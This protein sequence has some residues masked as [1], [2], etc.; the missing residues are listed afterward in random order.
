[1]ILRG[2][3]FGFT[4][5]EIAEMIGMEEMNMDEIEQ[6]HRSRRF[7][8]RK[9]GEIRLRRTE[10]DFVEQ[11]LLTFRKKLDRRER[12]LKQTMSNE[13]GTVGGEQ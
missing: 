4:L 13:H 2:K 5:D 12:E 11:D 10:L 8:D 1:M 7:V 6:I 9:V 3:R